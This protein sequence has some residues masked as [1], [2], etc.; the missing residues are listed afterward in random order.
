[1]DTQT[2]P[3]SAPKMVAR[4]WT[5]KQTQATIKQ[6]RAAGLK[7]DMKHPGFYECHAVAQG[8]NK[9][10]LVFAAMIGTRGYLVRHMD[11]LFEAAK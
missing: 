6:L 9:V 8:T 1:M 10:Q 3:Q 4:V 7:V 2:K 5:K 11:N